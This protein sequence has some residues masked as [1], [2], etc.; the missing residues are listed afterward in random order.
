[1]MVSMSN[2]SL[3]SPKELALAIGV[4][5]STLKRWADEGLVQVSRT[6][7][8]HRRIPLPEALRF[9]RET[10]ATIVRPDLLDLPE[11]AAAQSEVWSGRNPDD[12]I[13]EALK[14][15]DSVK[16]RGLI[17]SGYLSGRSL[18]ALC[19]G[20]I[21]ESM[22]RLGDLWKHDELGILIEHRATDIIIQALNQLRSIIKP[23]TAGLGTALG[24]TPGAGAASIALGGAAEHDPYILPSLMC[25]TLLSEAGYRDINFGPQTPVDVFI[26][27]S[28]Q[29]QPRL[30]WYT[31]SVNEPQK[32]VPAQMIELADT[33]LAMKG[34]LI[35]GGRG[36]ESVPLP[37]R[38]NVYRAPSMGELV[39]FARGKLAAMNTNP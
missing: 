21:R 8:G 9:V 38:P 3:L 29:Y 19:D 24:S 32:I 11:L 33:L 34:S 37:D 36:I 6:A 20:P 5:E 30:V 13:F 12:A 1:M 25:A 22:H 15:G 27:A 4:S 23:A 26:R 16:A 2:K 14:E 7:G 39:A 17:L 35:I 31:C 18:A 28:R 10:K